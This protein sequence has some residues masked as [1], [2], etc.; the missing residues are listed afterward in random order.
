M[1]VTRAMCPPGSID[2]EVSKRLHYVRSY[3]LKDGKLFLSM[4]ADG[5]VFEFEPAK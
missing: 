1:A 2:H 3:V 4:M 5:G